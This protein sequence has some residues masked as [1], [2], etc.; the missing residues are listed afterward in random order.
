MN[1]ERRDIDEERDLTEIFKKVRRIEI[2]TKRMVND[3][4]SGEYH[5]VFKGQGMEFDE[6]R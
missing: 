3:L 6:V 2:F 1:D 5:S 4:F